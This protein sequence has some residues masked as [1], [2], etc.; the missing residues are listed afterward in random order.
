MSKEERE[1]IVREAGLPTEI[2]PD[3]AL[4]LKADLALPWAKMREISR[5]T[6]PTYL[7]PNLQSAFR[8][9]KT[10][11]ISV[12][13]E[14]KQQALA[15]EDNMAAELGAFTFPRDGGGEDIREAPFVYVPNIIRKAA[16]LVEQHS[17]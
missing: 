14:V 6:L 12:G 10:L 5:Y 13:S 1:A 4:A 17:R 2:P 8:W 3:H 11:S 16:D 9:L 15:K 7:Y